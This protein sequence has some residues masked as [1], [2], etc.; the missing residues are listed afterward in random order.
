[1]FFYKKLLTYHAEIALCAGPYAVESHLRGVNVLGTHPVALGGIVGSCDFGATVHTA[2]EETVDGGNL[3]AA[4]KIE[5]R[6]AEEV[7][8]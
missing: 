8:A 6:Q 5:V 7:T 3:H 1:M 2:L 4:V